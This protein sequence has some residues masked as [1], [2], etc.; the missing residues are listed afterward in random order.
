M[1]LL[2]LPVTRVLSLAG[3]GLAVAA[4]VSLGLLVLAVSVALGGLRLA[5]RPG[6]GLRLVC[7]GLVCPGL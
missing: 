6:R 1:I 2:R 3:L 5:L 7:L 4:V